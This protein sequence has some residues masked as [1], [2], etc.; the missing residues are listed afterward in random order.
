MTR[1]KSPRVPL[2]LKWRG[3]RVEWQSALRGSRYVGFRLPWRRR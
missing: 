3:W 1:P 2:R